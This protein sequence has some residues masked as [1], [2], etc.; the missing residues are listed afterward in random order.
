MKWA[1]AISTEDNIESSIEEATENILFQL[2]GKSA[3]LSVIFVSPHFAEHYHKIPS[4]IGKRLNPGLLFGCS[5]GGIIGAGQEAEQQPAFSITCAHLPGV[6]IQPIQT[7]TME[8]PNQ[9]TGPGVWH[10]D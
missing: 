6:T 2:D 7:D 8:L 5:G 10:P 9:D 3:D 1:S 4:M